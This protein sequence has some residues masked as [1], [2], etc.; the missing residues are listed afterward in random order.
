[1]SKLN[2]DAAKRNIDTLRK[3]KG[4]TQAQLADAIGMSQPNL[5][6][7]LN[8]KE[9]RFFSAD[10]LY[11]IA[12]LF[13]VSIDE[14]LLRESP[15]SSTNSLRSIAEFIID[16][17][18]RDI[19]DL[20]TIE[21]SEFVKRVYYDIESG[22]PRNYSDVREVKRIALYFPNNAESFEREDYAITGSYDEDRIVT[23]STGNEP[24]NAFLEKYP[25]ILQLYKN[26]DLTRE[27][28]DAVVESSLSQLDA[29]ADIPF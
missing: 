2:Y 13:N 8:I 15:M 14:L 22:Y 5:N 26:N 10:Q 24:L 11:S 29:S 28:Y 20:E 9:K 3:N 4:L 12:D 23:N 25:H 21:T 16:L 6:K 1:M 7:A 19:I 27:A 17:L 18:E